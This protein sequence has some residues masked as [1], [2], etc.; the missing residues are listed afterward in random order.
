MSESQIRSLVNVS[1][2][3]DFSEN[4]GLNGS[5]INGAE[6]GS[7]QAGKAAQQ[8]GALTRPPGAQLGLSGGPDGKKVLNA[9]AL[10]WAPTYILLWLAESISKADTAAFWANPNFFPTDSWNFLI[11]EWE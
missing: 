7:Q 6:R 5:P 11:P 9:V 3:W 1:A 10:N 4:E 2:H 8:T